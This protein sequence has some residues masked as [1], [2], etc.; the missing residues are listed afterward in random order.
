MCILKD[1]VFWCYYLWWI[2]TEYDI[3]SLFPLFYINVETNNPRKKMWSEL[4][5]NGVV[6][7]ELEFF[8]TWIVRRWWSQETNYSDAELSAHTEIT[9]TLHRNH[10]SNT[11]IRPAFIDIFLDWTL[12]NKVS[13]NSSSKRLGTGENISNHRGS[14]SV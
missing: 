4:L 14:N 10:A 7:K 12:P 3:N 13:T 8:I 11:F 6:V 9:N 5:E 2:V 1:L